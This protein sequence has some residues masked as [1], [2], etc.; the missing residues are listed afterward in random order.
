MAI[1]FTESH[2]AWVEGQGHKDAV[3]KRG[4]ELLE[5]YGEMERDEFS[6]AIGQDIGLGTKTTNL[7]VGQLSNPSAASAPWRRVKRKKKEYISRKPGS[8][9]HR[10]EA[11]SSDKPCAVRPCNAPRAKGSAYCAWHSEAATPRGKGAADA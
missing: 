6:E 4:N 11:E 5:Q 1:G 9:A 10:T 2:D 3:L 8:E 7:W